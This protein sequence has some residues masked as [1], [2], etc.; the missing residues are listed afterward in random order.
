[1]VLAAFV[2]LRRGIQCF[3]RLQTSD[4]EHG[5]LMGLGVLTALGTASPVLSSLEP[6][7][8]RVWMR[9]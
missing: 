1:M 5:L 9:G 2:T 8:I 3:A 7:L 4:R 6:F